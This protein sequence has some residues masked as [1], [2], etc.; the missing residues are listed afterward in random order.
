MN[1]CTICCGNRYDVETLFIIKG[2]ELTFAKSLL[3]AIYFIHAISFNPS[4]KYYFHFKEK[5]TKAQ[6]S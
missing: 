6:R 4:S 1:V 2:K 5:E 3:C